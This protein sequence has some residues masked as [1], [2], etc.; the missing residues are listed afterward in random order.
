[1]P[2]TKQKLEKAKQLI[3]QK[4]YEQAR[5]VLFQLPDSITAQ[6]WLLNL[7]K[8]APPAKNT[9]DEKQLLEKAKQYIIKKDFEQAKGILSQLPN[10]STA[11]KWLLKLDE[12][13]PLPQKEP[14]LKV[15]KKTVS[16]T[17][18]LPKLEKTPLPR[19]HTT[20]TK[21]PPSSKTRQVN[22]VLSQ[23][24]PPTVHPLPKAT[25]RQDTPHPHTRRM[26][27]QVDY[28]YPTEHRTYTITLVVIAISLF[29]FTTISFGTLLIIF[30]IGFGLNYLF[31]RIETEGLK[32]SAVRVSETQFPEIKALVDECHQHI[33]IPSDTQVFVSYSPTMN[34]YAMGVGQPYS[35]ILYSALVEA[36]DADELK[37]VIGHEMGHIKFKHTV[38]LTLVGQL[39]EQ[40]FGMP[41]VGTLIRYSFMFWTRTTEFSADRAGLVACGRLDKAISAEVKLA[42][43]PELAK[44]VDMN[45]LAQQAKETHGNI[46]GTLGEMGGTHPMMTTRIQQM[47]DFTFSDD[48]MQLR[49]DVINAHF[50][51]ME[52]WQP[53]LTNSGQPAR[54]TTNISNRSEQAKK[55]TGL[56]I[57]KGAKALSK[58]GQITKAVASEA[59]AAKTVA[60]VGTAAKTVMAVGQTAGKTVETVRKTA[61]T[62]QFFMIVVAISIAL[63]ALS[64]VVMV[65]NNLIQ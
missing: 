6:N 3:L 20:E 34:A 32:R 16:V 43:G 4:N 37:S 7:D 60:N 49:P 44:Q 13:A 51:E 65:I 45:A 27:S 2:D 8:I 28:R 26:P 48:F 18:S 42:V 25:S 39:G 64:A 10:S 50:G 58:A 54:L 46:L 40:S 33:D 9:L 35:I 59:N 29:F 11:Q 1:M 56:V 53:A 23:A 21:I 61:A 57:N 14:T 52:H 5:R 12:F 38:L 55:T 15:P 19:Q 41:L 22:A 30:L 63:C 62:T 17:N 36:L 24:S 47:V 31:I